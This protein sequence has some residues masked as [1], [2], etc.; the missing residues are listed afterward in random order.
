MAG[1]VHIIAKHSNASLM[2]TAL[3]V[4]PAKIPLVLMI[5]LIFGKYGVWGVLAFCIAKDPGAAFI[6]KEL[7]VKAGIETFII[8]ETF[9]V[10]K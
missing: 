3:G 7:S 6:L 4:C 9:A 2:Y 1:M 8:E 5:V 10:F